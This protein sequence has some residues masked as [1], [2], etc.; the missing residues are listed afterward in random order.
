MGPYSTQLVLTEA[1]KLAASPFHSTNQALE[2]I[3][4]YGLDTSGGL[5]PFR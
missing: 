5:V 3:N 2:M 4:E 1:E